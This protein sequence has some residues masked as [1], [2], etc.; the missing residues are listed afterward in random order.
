MTYI[1]QEKNLGV[2]NIKKYMIKYFEYAFK[3]AKI[4]DNIYLDIF[5][6]FFDLLSKTHYFKVFT[7]PILAEVIKKYKL[8]E[9][10]KSAFINLIK[11]IVY[12][13]H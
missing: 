5:S 8:M 2:P 13:L 12:I 1:F 6:P 3:E 9:K 10:Y 11:K 7:I 4:Y